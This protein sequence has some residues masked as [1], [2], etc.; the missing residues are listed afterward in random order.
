MKSNSYEDD[1]K[2]TI[3]NKLKVILIISE[4]MQM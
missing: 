1:H 2:M 4:C 3:V